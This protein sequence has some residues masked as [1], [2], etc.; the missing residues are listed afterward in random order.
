[1]ELMRVTRLGIFASDN[2]WN[3]WDTGGIGNWTGTAEGIEQ[4]HTVSDYLR[5]NQNFIL[6]MVLPLSAIIAIV[7][8]WDKKMLGKLHIVMIGLSFWQL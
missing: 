7:V 2:I 5:L 8:L 4:G 6:T 3:T 1:M